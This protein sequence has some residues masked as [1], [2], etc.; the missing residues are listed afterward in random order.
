MPR[1]KA[2]WKESA[3][4]PSA[5][6]TAVSAT[7]PPPMPSAGNL[8]VGPG[9]DDEVIAGEELRSGHHDEDQ[10]EGKGSPAQ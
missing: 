8:A 1:K 2:S 3:S 9:H 6:R 10:A 5:M 4:L 7:A